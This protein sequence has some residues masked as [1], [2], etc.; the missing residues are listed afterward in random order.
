MEHNSFWF[1]AKMFIYWAKLH[2][3]YTQ[4]HRNSTSVKEAGRKVRKMLRKYMHTYHQ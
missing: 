4:K 3:F 1:M 2:K